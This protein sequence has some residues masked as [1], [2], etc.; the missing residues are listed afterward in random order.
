MYMIQNLIVASHV[1]LQLHQYYKYTDVNENKV[2]KN[3][4]QSEI[5][6][7]LQSDRI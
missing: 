2:V 6:T 7:I 3:Q 1:K 4:I 5:L